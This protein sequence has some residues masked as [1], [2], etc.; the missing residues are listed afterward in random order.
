MDSTFTDDQARPG[1]DLPILPISQNTVRS[2]IHDIGTVKTRAYQNVFD[3]LDVDGTGILSVADIK[4]AIQSLD[5]DPEDDYFAG[6]MSQ[7]GLRGRE[8]LATGQSLTGFNFEEFVLLMDNYEDPELED[9]HISDD[10]SMSGSMSSHDSDEE[11]MV[12]AGPEDQVEWDTD[13]VHVMNSLYTQMD[14][15]QSNQITVDEVNRLMRNHEQRGE[16]VSELQMM[17]YFAMIEKAGTMEDGCLSRDNF[18]ELCEEHPD[19][20]DEYSKK[21]TLRQDSIKSQIG[22]QSS[23]TSD[24]SSVLDDEIITGYKEVFGHFDE[25]KTG[26]ITQEDVTRV[27]HS[28]GRVTTAQENEFLFGLL[29]FASEGGGLDFEAYVDL[30]ESGGVDQDM[31]SSVATWVTK[32]KSRQQVISKAKS[33]KVSRNVLQRGMPK[34]QKGASR[35]GLDRGP[36]HGNLLA[37]GASAL[38]KTALKSNYKV[39]LTPMDDVAGAEEVEQTHFQRY[40]A[41]F[42]A[43]DADRDGRLTEAEVKSRVKDVIGRQPLDW[44]VETFMKQAAVLHDRACTF[45]EFLA[46]MKRTQTRLTLGLTGMDMFNFYN[47][48]VERQKKQKYGELFKGL[49]SNGNGSLTSEQIHSGLTKIGKQVTQEACKKLVSQFDNGKGWLTVDEFGSLIEGVM[50]T[51]VQAD[52][53]GGSKEESWSSGGGSFRGKRGSVHAVM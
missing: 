29:N 23:L 7:Q 33:L 3:S 18:F 11:N 36:S 50:R 28:M 53:V 49:D 25:G 15:D 26:V 39:D 13:L 47:D 21:Q 19:F 5:M 22:R 16:H 44:E 24:K 45:E 42:N 2:S 8:G 14:I 52:P 17:F 51:K 34:I 30:M 35:L 31:G 43:M 46:L 20:L 41:I 9:L 1:P 12:P 40:Q 48:T 38:D 4:H 10:S 32:R 27:M 37:V 6:A